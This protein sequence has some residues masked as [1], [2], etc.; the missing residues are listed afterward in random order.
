MEADQRMENSCE[1]C[2]ENKRTKKEKTVAL[3]R[4]TEKVIL[5]VKPEH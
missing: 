3:D 4:T 2:E 1:D 5:A